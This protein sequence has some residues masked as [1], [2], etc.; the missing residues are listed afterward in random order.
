[1]A[2]L[3]AIRNGLINTI[4][5]GVQSELFGYATVD[6]L[7]QLPAIIVEPAQA[8]FALSMNSGTDEWQF[9][10]FV[11]CSRADV[12]TGQEQ[13]DGFVS[14]SGPDSIRT[15]L[16]DRSDL[17]LGADTDSIVMRMVGY[18]GTFDTARVPL[19][20]AVLKVHVYTNGRA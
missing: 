15:A 17:G 9:N 6:D 12:Q 16:S 19:V 4:S 8:D 13:L 20:G 2:S 18:G 1:M 3:E 14:G 7:V 5:H 10:V 11:V